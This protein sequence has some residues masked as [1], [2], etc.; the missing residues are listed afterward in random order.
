[1]TEQVK[2]F[3]LPEPWTLSAGWEPNPRAV[4]DTQ[5]IYGPPHLGVIAHV[6]MRAQGEASVSAERRAIANLILAAPKMLAALKQI[7]R[8]NQQYNFGS[9]LMRIVDA[10]IAAAEPQP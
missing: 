2:A 7:K 8:D 10:A 4:V 9:K 5:N 6:V 3:A 1:M